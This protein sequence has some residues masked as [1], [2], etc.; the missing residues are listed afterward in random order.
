MKFCLE[1]GEM[2]RHL[3]EFDFNQ[4]LGEL[5]IRVN[6]K[7]IKRSVRLFD[8]PLAETHTLRVGNQ[9]DLVVRIEKERKMLFGQKCRVFL[10][11]RLYK[12]YEGV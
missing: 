10:N 2:E 5:R 7:E 6:K 9:E 11:D 3:V 1:V 8:E 4:L 12:Y